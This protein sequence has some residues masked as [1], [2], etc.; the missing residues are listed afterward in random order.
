MICKYF[1]PFCGL[2]FYSVDSIF[3]FLVHA[4]QPGIWGLGS[5]YAEP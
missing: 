3:V 4:V 5:E 2:P 1:L